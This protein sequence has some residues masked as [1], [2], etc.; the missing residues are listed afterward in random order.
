VLVNGA[1]AVEAGK[2]TGV[3]TGKVLRRA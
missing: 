2:V 1:L 3:R